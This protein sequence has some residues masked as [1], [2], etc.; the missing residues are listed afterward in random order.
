MLYDFVTFKCPVEMSL[1]KEMVTLNKK[2]QNRLMVLN[3]T[4]AENVTPEK[5]WRVRHHL[6]SLVSAGYSGP[7]QHR[8]VITD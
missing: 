1:M 7:H 2:K 8:L 6:R 3:W 4:A 5:E